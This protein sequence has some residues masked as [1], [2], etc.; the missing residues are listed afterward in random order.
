M[1]PAAMKRGLRLFAP[2]P[3]DGCVSIDMLVFVAHITRRYALSRTCVRRMMYRSVSDQAGDGLHDRTIGGVRPRANRLNP[4][5]ERRAMRRPRPTA[6][7]M[8]DDR[9]DA[10]AALRSQE[11]FRQTATARSEVRSRREGSR[12]RWFRSETPCR[13]RARSRPRRGP[14]R[15]T[16]TLERSC[17]FPNLV[18]MCCAPDGRP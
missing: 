9:P 7:R 10:S 14:T 3:P 11:L 8:S 18:S 4:G 6:L 16:S 5:R 13:R 15:C 12:D 17:G 2:L 1:T